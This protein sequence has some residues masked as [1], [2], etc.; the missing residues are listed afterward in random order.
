MVFI[1]RAF[2]VAASGNE[3]AGAVGTVRCHRVATVN[4]TS[5]DMCD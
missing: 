1:V 5:P 2:Q 4:T 3:P